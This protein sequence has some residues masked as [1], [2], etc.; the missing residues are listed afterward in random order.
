M[1]QAPQIHPASDRATLV[2]FASEPRRWV[3]RFTAALRAAA[4]PRVRNVHPAWDSVLVVFDPRRTTHAEIDT[5]LAARLAAAAAMPAPAGR[6]VEIPVCYGGEFGP[7][8]EDVARAHELRDED[9]IRLH[10]EPHYDVAFL[11]FAPGFP[12]LDG[13]PKSL[14]TPRRDRPRVRVPAGSVGIGGDHTGVYPVASPGGWQIIGRTPLRLFDPDAA[15]E[16][17]EAV[18]SDAAA[19]SD[20]AAEPRAPAVTRLEMGDRVRFRRIA[21]HEFEVLRSHAPESPRSQPHDSVPACGAIAVESPGLLT[22]VQDSGRFGWGHLGISASGCADPLALA[23]GNRLVGNDDG[24]AALEMTLV[25]GTFVFERDALVAL[26]GATFDARS[27][28]GAVPWWEAWP[29]RAGTRLE[30]GPARTGARCVLCV[31]GGI[32]V[33]MF[34]GSASTHVVTG[35]GGVTGRA[36]ARGDR[37]AIGAAGA[38]ASAH[39]VDRGWIESLYAPDP[40]RVTPAPQADRFSP[41]AHRQLVESA[42]HVLEQSNRVGVRL[43]GAGLDA[44]DAGAL[45]TEGAALGAVQVPPDGQ[46]IVLFVEHQTT[47]GYP[48]IANVCSADLHRVGQLRPRDTLRFE[49]VSF[50]AAHALVRAREHDLATRLP[51]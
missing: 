40:I 27:D 32:D 5:L 44:P 18:Q 17:D 49:V 38:H 2:V 9:V 47:G 10:T 36:L 15:V 21:P 41:R 46:P 48:K 29:V 25:G 16:W 6:T 13:L 39:R 31:R 20:P 23:C 42:W 37:L 34:L 11:G 3:P 26:T 50:A 51:S 35:V 24:A 4:D 7:D 14:A 30:I 33:P 22:T 45:R 43:H 28:R 12:Y 19:E 8:L 1:T